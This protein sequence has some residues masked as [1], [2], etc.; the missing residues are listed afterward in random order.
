MQEIIV[1]VSVLLALVY[2]AQEGM[3]T[4]RRRQDLQTGCDHCSLAPGASDD[5]D[6]TSG[7]SA[8]RS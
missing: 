4:Y 5:S 8:S 6:Q 7:D 2:L 3:R 1:G